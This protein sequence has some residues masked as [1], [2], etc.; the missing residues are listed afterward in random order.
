MPDNLNSSLGAFVPT[1]NV[2]DVSQIYQTDVNSPEFKE[3]LVR[4]YQNINNIA[5]ILN[6]KDTGMYDTQEFLNGQ[7][8]FANPAYVTSA[9]PYPELRQVYRFTYNF[10][11]LPNSGTKTLAHGLPVTMGNYTFTRIF[12]CSSDTTNH[13]YIPIPYAGTTGNTVEINVD[14]VDIN[15]ITESDRSTFDTTYVVLE[16]L[17]T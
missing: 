17:I 16:Y 4:L 6:I 1:T 7:L 11:A 12:A 9:D 13:E 2:W 10:G 14:A 5:L 8:W 15:I 3:L